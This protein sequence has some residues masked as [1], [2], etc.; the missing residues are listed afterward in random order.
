MNTR[1]EN[2]ADNCIDDFLIDYQAIYENVP[3]G[4]M[5]FDMNGNVLWCN[6][7]ALNNFGYSNQEEVIGT[8]YSE[9]IHPDY[10]MEEVCKFQELK[11]CED[12]LI[13]DATFTAFRKDGTSFSAHVRTTP[14]IIEGELKGIQS[15]SRD[16]SEIESPEYKLRTSLSEIEILNGLFQHDFRND[17]HVVEN[18]LDAALMLMEENTRSTD[19]LSMAKSGLH[20]MKSL[21]ML[22]IPDD[23]EEVECLYD[24]INQRIKHATD[25]HLNLRV[26]LK[27]PDLIDPLMIRDRRLLAFIFD[28]LFRNSVKYAGADSTIVINVEQYDEV[29]LVEIVDDGPGISE[30]VRTT[31]FQR[32]VTTTGSGMGLYICRRILE[33]YGGRIDLLDSSSVNTGAAFRITLPLRSSEKLDE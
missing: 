22:M 4:I 23:T 10:R 3:D 9:Y 27:K 30:D 21:L 18:A 19:F 11:R 15:H 14:I 5:I 17:L 12:T 6:K 31:L 24:L 25:M 20:R 7:A 29:L 26:I 32:S 8:N 13:R 1:Y 28:N 2:S 16:I 33:S